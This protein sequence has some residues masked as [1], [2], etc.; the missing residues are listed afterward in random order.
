ML[1]DTFGSFLK[2]KYN[3]ILQIFQDAI[4]YRTILY[5]HVLGYILV[6]YIVFCWPCSGR[7]GIQRQNLGTAASLQNQNAIAWYEIFDETFGEARILT[8][9]AEIWC[10]SISLPQDIGTGGGK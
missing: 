5:Y 8:W 10:D 3:S 7:S 2:W 9:K 1:T 4:L 6:Y